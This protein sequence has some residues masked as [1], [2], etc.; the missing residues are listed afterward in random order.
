MKILQIID[1]LEVGGAERVFIDLTNLLY[2]SKKVEVSI[3]TFDN[4]G[5][6]YKYL[7]P[8]INKI[9]FKRKNKF[10]LFTAYKLSKILRNY[11]ILH[12]HMIHVFKYVKFICLIFNIKTKLVLQDHYGKNSTDKKIPKYL[13]TFLKPKYYIGVS[14]ELIDWA[15]ERLNVFNS[16]KL[17]N[18]VIKEKHLEITNDKKGFVI[19]GNIKPIKNQLFAIQLVIL[20]NEELTIVGKI[21]DYDYYNKLLALINKS[22]YKNKVHFIH[23]VNNVQPLLSQFKLGLMTSISESGPLV[24][25]EYLAQNLPFLSYETGEVSQNLKKEI[26]SFFIKNFIL[27]EWQEKIN[28]INNKTEA[29][30]ELYTKHYSEKKYTNECL[31]I[32]QKI[33]NS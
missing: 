22:N 32:Y 9:D 18:I 30:E 20:M 21:Q 19:V 8:Q 2:K 7:N 27:N 11:D 12:V 13:N 29:L 6:L 31:K 24:L 23:D 1:R 15:K 33:K 16:Y 10:N 25:I 26:P 28:L 3:L 17:T 4:R 5:G 14:E